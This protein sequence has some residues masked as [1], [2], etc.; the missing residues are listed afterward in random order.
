[1]FRNHTRRLAWA[2][3]IAGPLLAAFGFARAA[4]APYAGK[5]KVTIHR[6]GQSQT[7]WIIQFEDKNG[8]PDGKVTATSE[9]SLKNAKVEQLTSDDDAIRFAVQATGPQNNVIDFA[10]AAYYPKPGAK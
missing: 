3:A 8:K 4:N 1:M 7:L 2:I 5:W 10:F 6:P 9:R